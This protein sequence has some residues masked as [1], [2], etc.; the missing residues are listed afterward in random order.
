MRVGDEV[1]L[2]YENKVS[3]AR[4]R[5]ARVVLTHPDE[6]N[7]VQTVTVHLRMRHQQEKVLPYKAKEMTEFR[8]A[9]Q[10]LVLIVPAEEQSERREEE[11]LV[12]EDESEQNTE[13]MDHG[14]ITPL[15]Y[16]KS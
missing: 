16:P 4:Y 5:L 9:V 11:Q 14:N 12:I 6:C 15:G 7:V 2:R 3:Q 10:R 1:L 13:Q 8:V